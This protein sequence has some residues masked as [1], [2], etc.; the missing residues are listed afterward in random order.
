M[1]LCWLFFNEL[2]FAFS[3]FVCTLYLQNFGELLFFKLNV[4][5]YILTIQMSN[6]KLKISK[7]PVSIT[8][9]NTAYFHKKNDF[10]KKM[11]ENI[12]IY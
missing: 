9:I 11:I 5:N 1:F 7:T 2:S 10:K 4:E 12:F 8:K 3:L 6:F